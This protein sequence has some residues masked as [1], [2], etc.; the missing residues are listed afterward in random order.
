MKRSIV[1]DPERFGGEPHIEGTSIT[2]AEVQAY[3]RKPGVGA[4]EIRIEFPQLSEAELGAAVT[5][6]ELRDPVFAYVAESVGPPRRRLR[7]WSEAAKSWMFAVD[8]ISPDGD[9]RCVYD[10]WED[11]WDRIILYPEV[12][13]PK[14][15]VWRDDRSGDLIDI[16]AIKPEV[17]DE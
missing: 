12:H 9:V 3:W 1:R 2:V 5:Y 7:I 13:A 4:R 10:T 6:S 11:S 8:E 15:I 17:R 14:S 16:Y